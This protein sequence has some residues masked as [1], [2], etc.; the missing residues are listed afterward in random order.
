MALADEDDLDSIYRNLIILIYN[1]K[2][3]WQDQNEMACDGHL[4]VVNVISHRNKLFRWDLNNGILL[5]ES[6]KKWWSDN[7]LEPYKFLHETHPEVANFHLMNQGV[8]PKEN[9]NTEEIAKFLNEIYLDALREGRAP[10][11]SLHGTLEVI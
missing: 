7:K 1:K 8:K 3:I 5:C 9:V 4:E 6:H 10:F 11:P 2:C